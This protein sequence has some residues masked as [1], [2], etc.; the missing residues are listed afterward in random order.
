MPCLISVVGE[1]E[2]PGSRPSDNSVYRPGDDRYPGGPPYRPGTGGNKYPPGS[3]GSSGEKYPPKLPPRYPPSSGDYDRPPP[4]RPYNDRYPEYDDR[5]PDDRYPDRGGQ[6]YPIGP[7]YPPSSS[8][9]SSGRYPYYP[10][11]SS[12]KPYY[13]DR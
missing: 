3:G 7:G 8:G 1:P 12:G 11:S 2:S 6:R 10:P 4:R 5:Y 13:T 9:S